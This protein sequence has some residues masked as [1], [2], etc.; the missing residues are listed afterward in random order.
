MAT[1]YAPNPTSFLDEV[2]AERASDNRF[3]ELH[4]SVAKLEAN[5][6]RYANENKTEIVLKGIEAFCA[7]APGL[8]ATMTPGEASRRAQSDALF[9]MESLA[10]APAVIKAYYAASKELCD[11]LDVWYDEHEIVEAFG[12]KLDWA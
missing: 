8:S 11:M 3:K 10:L 12:A 5:L 4:R 1:I 2:R 9:T 6:L 7:S